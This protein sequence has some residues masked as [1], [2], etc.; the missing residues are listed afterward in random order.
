MSLNHVPLKIP[1]V[2]SS[3][4]AVHRFTMS[5]FTDIRTR[6]WRRALQRGIRMGVHQSVSFCVCVCC[7][8]FF[9]LQQI[10]DPGKA[11]RSWVLRAL[12]HSTA[13]RAVNSV[14]NTLV[15]L[16]H[17]DLH[18]HPP[19]LTFFFPFINVCERHQAHLCALGLTVESTQQHH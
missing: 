18:K 8:F 15:S 17:I 2:F 16:S 5:R 13:V 9:F 6:F 3:V 14:M 1:F 19:S 11:F 12:M 10:R 7:C 4:W